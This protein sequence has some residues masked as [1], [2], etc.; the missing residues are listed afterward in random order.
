MSNFKI[1]TC[2]EE[3]EKLTSLDSPE[4]PRAF[5]SIGDVHDFF[6]KETGI[7]SKTNE[8]IIA[9]GNILDLNGKGT[10]RPTSKNDKLCSL[11][12]RGQDSLS[13]FLLQVPGITREKYQR[14]MAFSNKG[15]LD[16]FYIKISEKLLSE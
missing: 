15:Y 14:I 4:D 8:F 5:E 11:P 12:G 9:I 13:M 1:I 10:Y 3:F 16:D 6:I 7:E 2:L